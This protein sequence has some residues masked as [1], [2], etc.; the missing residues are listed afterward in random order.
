[1][2]ETI[3]PEMRVTARDCTHSVSEWLNLLGYDYEEVSQFTL[4][5]NRNIR[6]VVLRLIRFAYDGEDCTYPFKNRRR[7][8]NCIGMRFGRLIA[9]SKVDKQTYLCKCDCGRYTKAVRC[10]L[11]IGEV[12]SCGCL[13][14]EFQTVYLHSQEN[15]KPLECRRLV[16]NGQNLSITEWSRQPE[17]IARGIKRRNIYSRLRAGWSIEKTLTEPCNKK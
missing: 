8:K 13:Q 15:G 2:S 16:Y 14:K 7:P 1:M 9:V 3:R 5:T 10:S 6:D 4:D 11:V 17:I 12:R